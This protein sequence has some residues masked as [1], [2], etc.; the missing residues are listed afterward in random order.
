MLMLCLW[1][2]SSSQ[3]LWQSQKLF[4]F[5]YSPN[6]RLF[7]FFVDP[8]YHFIS[9]IKKLKFTMRS[10]QAIGNSWIVEFRHLIS[11]SSHFWN[12][13]KLMDT[14]FYCFFLRW[15]TLNIACEHSHLLRSC[16]HRHSYSACSSATK[17][18]K[19]RNINNFY[20]CPPCP[21]PACRWKF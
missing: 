20:S 21:L 8:F 3:V 5:R 12:R 14:S 6:Y 18:D 17:S 2:K 19:K 11:I 16:I 1:F 10:S 9:N 7:H 4:I 13:K 15:P